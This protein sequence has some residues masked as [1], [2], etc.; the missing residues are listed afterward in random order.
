MIGFLKSG[1]LES[2]FIVRL[3]GDVNP[4]TLRIGDFVVINGE[5]YDYFGI[6]ED[7]VITSSS[8]DVFFDPPESEYEKEA[9]KGTFIFSEALVSPYLMVEKGTGSVVSVKTIPQHF[10]PV[11]KAL[12]EDFAKIFGE[13]VENAFSVGTPLTMEEPIYISLKELSKRNNAIF[14]ITGSGKTFLARIIFSG[15]I[16]QNVSSL[17]IFD[18]HNEYG[19]FAK[20]EDKKK[21]KGLKAIFDNKVKVFDVSKKNED[22]DEFITI[23]YKDIKAADVE[24]LSTILN[25]S[26]KS[27]ETAFIIERKK[28]TG[29][30]E[31]VL[32]LEGL[33]EKELAE[34]AEEIGVNASALGALVRHLLK[35]K[36]LGFIKNTNEESSVRKILKYL[37]AGVS[38]VVQFS[39]NAASNPL[40]YFT[41]ANVI[42]RRIHD[43]FV[44][45]SEEEREKSRVMIVIEEA[46]KLLSTESKEKNIFGTIAREMRKF[47][48]TLFIVDQRPSE[49]DADVLSQVGTRFVLQLMDEKDMNAVFQ[50]VGGG[51]KLKKILRTLQPREA[52]VFGYAVRMPIAVRVR[53]YGEEFFKEMEEGSKIPTDEA[54]EDLF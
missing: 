43:E 49:I 20:S 14:G 22:A 54:E 8:E 15:M 45:M 47:N 34:R 32:S 6:I 19:R 23:P 1:S 12:A 52:L 31:Y 48:V 36:R 16:K 28:G 9:L 53:E 4:E 37:K 46:H 13:N 2:G 25:F 10:S 24:M 40:A 11:K 18:M 29:W 44:N 7:L 39:G 26:D 35:F 42:S 41:V 17:L 3:S 27:A 50:G 51:A 30:L 38:V 5:L 21:I 33:G